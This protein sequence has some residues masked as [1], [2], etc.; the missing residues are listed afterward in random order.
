MRFKKGINS[1]VSGKLTAKFAKG[2]HGKE[3][4][5]TNQAGPERRRKRDSDAAATVISAIVTTIIATVVTTVV[6]AVITAIAATGF[7]YF[8]EVDNLW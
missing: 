7:G 6:T 8:L 1:G 2:C 3:A 4:A 5:E